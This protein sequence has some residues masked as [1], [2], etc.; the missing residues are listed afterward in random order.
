MSEAAVRRHAVRVT[1]VPARD[2]ADVLL[3]GGGRKLERG[4]AEILGDATRVDALRGGTTGWSRT[5]PMLE[6][7]GTLD[8]EATVVVTSVSAEVD[9]P[10]PDPREALVALAQT[11]RDR[12]GRLVVLNASSVAPRDG[13][14]ALDLRIRRLNLAVVE[15]SHEAGFSVL[16]ADRIVTEATVSEKIRGPFDYAPEVCAA[17][18]AAFVAI[19]GDLGLTPQP[20]LELRVPFV[21]QATDLRVERWLKG[22]GDRVEADD[23]ICEI[24]MGHARRLSRPTSAV[25]LASLGGR[26][27]LFQR[28]ASR[29][30]VRRRS[31]SAVLSVVA[32]DDAVLR[33]ITR[34]AGEPVRSGDALGILTRDPESEL[35]GAVAATA[36]VFR[37][38][39]RTDDPVI[40][41][42]L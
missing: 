3:G 25:V 12:D 42:M 21:R 14:D 29:E 33:R 34:R 19:L 37:A 26:T 11:I 16:D 41:A 8:G 22:E 18:R 2:V 6:A 5:L 36:G 13:A 1:F 24:K 35:V 39:M 10:S 20:V 32:R 7:G 40:E 17:L 23:T 4:L 9:D 28:L 38:V 31:R 30:R 27:P 15:A